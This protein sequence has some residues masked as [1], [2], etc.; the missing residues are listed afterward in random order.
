MA[1]IINMTAINAPSF[2]FAP[3]IKP[4]SILRSP[5]MKYDITRSYFLLKRG[6]INIANICETGSTI[7]IMSIVDLGVIN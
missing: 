6:I 3:S 1:T 7:A 2:V 4:T 5:T